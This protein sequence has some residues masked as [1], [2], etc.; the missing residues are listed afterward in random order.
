MVWQ[1]CTIEWHH[2]HVIN[3]SE[4]LEHNEVVP[5]HGGL[6]NGVNIING[7]CS[8]L[9]QSSFIPHHVPLKDWLGKLRLFPSSLL[10]YQL[11]TKQPR[12]GHAQILQ[13]LI[14]NR[15]KKKKPVYCTAW[16]AHT[17]APCSDQAIHHMTPEREAV[18]NLAVFTPAHTSRNTLVTIESLSF[19]YT[20]TRRYTPQI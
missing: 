5:L 17:F 6:Q 18:S 13:H 10:L 1:K 9:G 19:P 16:Q 11:I 4:L 7:L 2:R 8:G 20:A 3:H 15:Y 12:K 14:K